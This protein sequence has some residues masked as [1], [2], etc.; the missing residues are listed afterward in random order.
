MIDKK[1]L[2]AAAIELSSWIRC[3]WEY[4]DDIDISDRFP[5]WACNGIGHL[6][7]QGGRPAVRKAAARV[8]TAYLAALPPVDDVTGLVKELRGRAINALEENTATAR[9]DAW[10]FETSATALERV[11]RE[12]DEASAALFAEIR[13]YDDAKARAEAAEARIAEEAISA[14]EQATPFTPANI[15]SFSERN[16]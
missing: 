16:K 2:E 13:R 15:F 9:A 8:I 6:H 11:A 1:A 3:G 10:Y 7:M 5:D 4:L 14:A 12:R